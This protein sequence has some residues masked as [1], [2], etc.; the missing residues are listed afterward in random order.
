MLYSGQITVFKLRTKEK[1][2]LVAKIQR[3]RS[4]SKLYYFLFIHGLTNSSWTLRAKDTSRHVCRGGTA[5]HALEKKKLRCHKLETKEQKSLEEGVR[6]RGR[7]WGRKG[8]TQEMQVSETSALMLFSQLNHQYFR[9][10][11]FTHILFQVHSC[12]DWCSCWKSPL[13]RN[14]EGLP[15]G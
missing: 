6:K 14:L 7:E 2:S 3:R 13:K 8:K 5:F 12:P 15:V 10:S 11:P 9:H 1:R 4:Y